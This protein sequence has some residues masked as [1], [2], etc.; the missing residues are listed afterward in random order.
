MRKGARLAMTECIEGDNYDT[1][2]IKK[3]ALGDYKGPL[4]TTLGFKATKVKSFLRAKVNGLVMCSDHYTAVN[5]R[6]SSVVC[7]KPDDLVGRVQKLLGVRQCSCF[8]AKCQCK[9]VYLVEM[10]RFSSHPFS[11]YAP[12][13]DFWDPT[14]L[15]CTLDAIPPCIRTHEIVSQHVLAHTYVHVAMLCINLKVRSHSY[16]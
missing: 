5:E 1:G 12:F 13:P 6:V 3:E 10:R 7:V 11:T 4:Q 9:P 14:T 16:F 2:A 15:Y 8:L